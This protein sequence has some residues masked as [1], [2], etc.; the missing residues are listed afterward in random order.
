MMAA[1]APAARA[2]GS[3]GLGVRRVTAR[4]R[5]VRPGRGNTARWYARPD[6]PG[7]AAAAALRPEAADVSGL[8]PGPAHV[9]VH[10]QDYLP[11][12][13]I[14]ANITSSRPMQW[15]LTVTALFPECGPEQPLLLSHNTK[16]PARGPS[17]QS[18]GAAE[19]PPQHRAAA[20][21][22]QGV[23]TAAAAGG[24]SAEAADGFWC[25]T[26]RRCAGALR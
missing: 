17:S 13:Q 4:S 16:R 6:G 25:A 3:L 22:G 19:A 2:T 15:H 1:A 21:A 5:R 23:A 24:R 26:A 20:N 14:P 7:P 9:L 18:K 10:W 8:G 12:Y 11:G